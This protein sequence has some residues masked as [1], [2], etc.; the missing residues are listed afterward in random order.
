MRIDYAWGGTI[1]VPLTRV[2]IMGRLAPN[3]FCSPGYSGHGVN[4]T[5]RAGRLL[6]EAVAGTLE[7]FD[8][9]AAIRPLVVPRA[10]ALGR[11]MVV[12]GVLYDQFRDR[13]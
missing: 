2:P 1:G 5:H 12:L 6:A 8:V 7:R 11:P 3:L 13:L 4:V 10:H 9:F